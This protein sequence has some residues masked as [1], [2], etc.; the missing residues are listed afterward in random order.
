MNNIFGMPDYSVVVPVYN[1]HESLRELY[2]QTAGT[3]G[4]IGKSFEVIFVDDASADRSWEVISK[5]Q[6][7]FPEKVVGIKLARNFGQHNAT[8]C[9]LA[10]SSS[11]YIITIDD[12]LQNPPEDIVKLI[13]RMKETDADVV[14]GIFSKKHH[15]MVHNMGSATLK[16]T[17]RRLF[18][19]KGAGSSFRL[20]KSSMVKNLLNHRIDFIYLD[21]LFNWYT[22]DI[23]FVTV[24]HNKRPYQQ[25]N[26]TS[27]SLFSLLTNLVI[28]Y[29]AIPLRL[30]V[31]GGIIASIIS[32][33]IGLVF[34]YRKL[35]QDVPLGFTAMIVAVL[36]S[37]S[38]ILLSLGVLGEYLS[39]IY[40]VQ[41]RK[42][43]YSIKTVLRS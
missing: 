4:R 12:D 11:E 22:S 29:T 32:F 37:T 9:G 13:E 25:S 35:F 15:S 36:F 18:Q 6:G 10:S 26:Y 17:S 28:Y 3:F 23:E 7:E 31:Y 34:I 1:S 19:T 16:G 14:Y 20:I 38:I 33:V 21:E 42:P 8:L 27:R 39:R 30:M 24:Q 5:L 2:S 43:P 40:N 41:N